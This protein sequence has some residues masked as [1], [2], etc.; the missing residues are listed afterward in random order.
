[1]AGLFRIT[2]PSRRYKGNVDL[3]IDV[4]RNN[5][6]KTEP[7]VF[8]EASYNRIKHGRTSDDT[9]HRIGKKVEKIFQN[10]IFLMKEENQNGSPWDQLTPNYARRKM[11]KYGYDK[12]IL[13][14]DK[15]MYKEHEH[16][17]S[18]NEVVVRNTNWKAPI[19]LNG[20]G[21]VPVRDWMH[22]DDSDEDKIM[23]MLVEDFHDFIT[24]KAG[25]IS[26]APWLKIYQ[27]RS[28]MPSLAYEMGLI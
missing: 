1:M 16:E 18:K 23:D 3:V 11:N 13:F 26:K 5:E 7:E 19:H 25:T 10:N 27:A 15:Q 12:P 20:L 17:I 24:T 8:F 4:P 14:A 22:L 21:N 9:L 28:G 2:R 6:G